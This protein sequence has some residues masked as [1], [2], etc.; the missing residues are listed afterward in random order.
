M[1]GLENRSEIVPVKKNK[2]AELY[3][4]KLILFDA[5][6]FL[7][8]AVNIRSDSLKGPTYIINV[9]KKWQA[10]W[11]WNNWSNSQGKIIKNA[12]IIKECLELMKGREIMFMKV[13]SHVGV[14]Y[15][16]LADKLAAI[17]TELD[18]FR[19]I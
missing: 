16:E 1:W 11:K 7:S 15:N 2:Q 3:A 5:S 18:K 17:G 12:E 4:V 19:R 9:L 14:Q 10:R 8:S 6:R 13:K